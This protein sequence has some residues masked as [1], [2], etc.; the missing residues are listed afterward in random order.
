MPRHLIECYDRGIQLTGDPIVDWQAARGNLTG[1]ADLAELFAKARLLR[2]FK[3]TDALA[4]GLTTAWDGQQSYVDAAAVVRRVLAIETLTATQYDAVPI[5]VMTLHKA[6][7]KEFDGVIIA[8]G[9]F[10]AR[11]LDPSWDD[12]ASESK[13]RLLRVGITRARHLVVFVR[14]DDAV[15]LLDL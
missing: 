1:T 14:P 8:E 15:P 2:L 6:K 12:Q 13:R 5:S 7:G 4:Q 3:A 10:N 11:L 9:R